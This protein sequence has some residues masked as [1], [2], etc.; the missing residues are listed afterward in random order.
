MLSATCE[1]AAALTRCPLDGPVEGTLSLV[2]PTVSPPPR[3]AVCG[4]SYGDAVGSGSDG[5]GLGDSAVTIDVLSEGGWNRAAPELRRLVVAGDLQDP[6]RTRMSG[7]HLTRGLG[8]DPSA[9]K[10]GQDEELGDVQDRAEAAHQ[11]QAGQ[12]TICSN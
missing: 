12:L 4:T 11:S 3:A 7:E 2:R 9:A 8:A 10:L 1:T 5:E 6:P